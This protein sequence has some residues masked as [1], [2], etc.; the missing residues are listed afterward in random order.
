MSKKDEIIQPEIQVAPLF[1]IKSDKAGK[2]SARISVHFAPVWPDGFAHSMFEPKTIELYS[3]PLKKNATIEDMK[4]A[5]ESLRQEYKKPKYTKLVAKEKDII[6]ARGF[7]IKVKNKTASK[8]TL[9]QKAKP[10]KKGK[11]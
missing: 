11:K 7:A 6:E 8:K 1:E 4:S 3:K 2:K 9:P 5:L 10:K